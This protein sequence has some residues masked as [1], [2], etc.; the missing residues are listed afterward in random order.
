MEEKRVWL[1][2]RKRK[3]TCKRKAKEMKTKLAN[4]VRLEHKKIMLEN[5]FFKQ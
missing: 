2:A 3:E 1:D 5:T 4:K